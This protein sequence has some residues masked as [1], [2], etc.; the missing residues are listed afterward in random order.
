MA[1][2]NIK[3]QVASIKGQVPSQTGRPTKGQIPKGQTPKGFLK[4]IL[5]EGRKGSEETGVG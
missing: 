4:P 3:T 1:R 5:T 2:Q